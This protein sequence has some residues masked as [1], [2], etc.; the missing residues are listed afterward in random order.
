MIHMAGDQEEVKTDP[1]TG[2]QYIVIDVRCVGCELPVSPSEVD[3][4]LFRVGI[5]THAT[6]A[7]YEATARKLH[8]GSVG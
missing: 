5:P 1:E 2:Q 7:C 6:E 8:G 4:D 3:W